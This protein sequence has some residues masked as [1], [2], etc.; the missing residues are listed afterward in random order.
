[1][2]HYNLTF[3]QIQTIILGASTMVLAVD[4]L[5]VFWYGAAMDPGHAFGFAALTLLSALIW[6]AR[7]AMKGLGMGAGGSV[8]LLVA[9]FGLFVGCWY[10]NTGFTV[11]MRAK[12]TLDAQVQTTAFDA[13]QQQKK[14]AAAKL[15]SMADEMNTLLTQ[16][17]WAK[18]ETKDGLGAGIVSLQK[19]VDLEAKRGGC[20]DKCQLKMATLGELQRKIGIVEHRDYL[21]SGIEK[22]TTEANVAVDKAEDTDHGFSR[23]EVQNEFIPQLLNIMWFGPSKKNPDVLAV[24]EANKTLTSILSAAFLS[25]LIVI[26]KDVGFFVGSWRPAHEIKAEMEQKPAVAYAAQPR[27]PPS[28]PNARSA[29]VTPMRLG[30]VPTMPGLAFTSARGIGLGMASGA[31]PAF[32]RAA[33]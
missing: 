30:V 27:V 25:L 17:D 11:S 12:S 31:M 2:P 29:T 4:M 33:A 6:P 5:M 16:N 8:V 18:A 9:G 13:R 32:V 7:Q 28:L 21:R 24:S 22:A 26:A 1:M 15:T 14:L 3:R 19:A 10:A 23:I 20:K